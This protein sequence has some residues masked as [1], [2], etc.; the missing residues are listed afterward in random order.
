MDERPG[1]DG[2]TS[3]PSSD[4]IE[5]MCA[6]HGPVDSAGR[7]AAG[8]VFG[9]WRLTAFIGRG[10]SGE[11]YCAKHVALGTSAAVKVLVREEERAKVRFA[12]ESKL[13][14]ELKSASFPRFYAFGEANGHAYLAMELLEPGNLPS[15]GK[16][17]ARFLLKVCDAVAELHA[18]GLVHRDIKP[19]NILW[20]SPTEP[21]L[22]DLGL[23]KAVGDSANATPNSQPLNSQLSTTHAAGTPGYGA[24]EQ[25][26][27]GEVSFAADVHAL[28]VLA[29]RCF[30][31]NPPR[32][33]ARI[34]ERA[35]S[36]IPAHRYP[37]VAAL[38]SAIRRRNWPRGAAVVLCG[39]S[40]AI[41]MA[42][43]MKD[44]IQSSWLAWK[45]HREAPV[46]DAAAFLDGK[47]AGE[48]EWFLDYVPVKMPYRFAETNRWGTLRDYRWLHAVV[49]RQGRVYSAKKMNI[50]PDWKGRRRISLNLHEDP[51]TGTVV[52]VWSP[53]GVPFD[54]AWCPPGEN[55]VSCDYAGTARTAR[56]Q[57]GCGYWMSTKKLTGRQHG[58][59]I[60]SRLCYMPILPGEK[61]D[62]TS[63][64]P[65][66]R[67][68]FGSSTVPTF[69]FPDTGM[70]FEPPDA[71]QWEHAAMEGGGNNPN[72]LG[73]F[74]MYDGSAE[75][76][77]VPQ[78]L[79]PKRDGGTEGWIRLGGAGTNTD[80]EAHG[81][82]N[83]VARLLCGLP[84][85]VFKDFDVVQRSTKAG[86]RFSATSCF[87]AETNA[88]LYCTAQGLIRSSRQEDVSLG[89]KMLQDLRSLKDRALATLAKDFPREISPR[90]GSM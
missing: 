39:I 12:R 85:P 28:G 31:G 33:W 63:D 38:A 84:A 20:R 4:P 10:G 32:A 72:S 68:Y 47:A 69:S 17:V 58:A 23:V 43:F 51:P 64:N 13:L 6:A 66:E 83:L 24:P 44:S 14:S 74:D 59:I 52:R 80:D 70:V 18:L 79:M 19:G 42:L 53:D 2:S 36:S 37:S 46:L 61:H 41:A 71:M 65:V 30:G 54:F 11:V 25:M 29:D 57:V 60:R 15:G 81:H 5:A 7:F 87:E 88:V 1:R 9:D 16:D 86:I 56:V 8:T 76:A 49:K 62:L 55:E 35:T 3:R 34:V 50:N 27:R 48:A 26:E 45:R 40:V 82:S 90:G 75:W 73:M 21:V 67:G 77:A 22:A 89:K 78:R